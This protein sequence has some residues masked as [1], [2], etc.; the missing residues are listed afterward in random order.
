ME[1]KEDPPLPLEEVLHLQPVTRDD[2]N[3]IGT[4]HIKIIQYYL[5][6]PL[7][8]EREDAETKGT[9]DRGVAKFTKTSIRDTIHFEAETMGVVVKDIDRGNKLSLLLCFE[10]NLGLTLP[11]LQTDDGFFEFYYPDQMVMA[12]GEQT[13]IVH[14]VEGI[15]PRLLI[16]SESVQDP[17]VKSRKAKGRTLQKELGAGNG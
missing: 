1:E 4:D 5:S 16:N 12:Y 10:D 8:L 9:A 3:L 7:R 6:A 11:F 14:Y 15:A 13:Y 17:Q 2:L